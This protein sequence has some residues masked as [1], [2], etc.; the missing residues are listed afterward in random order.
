V[1]IFEPTCQNFYVTYSTYSCIFCCRGSIPRYQSTHY[2][3]PEPKESISAKT[4]R[5]FSNPLFETIG[6]AAHAASSGDR[7][8]KKLN[9]EELTSLASDDD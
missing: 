3:P 5:W 4:A 6:I 1:K 2:E 8:E 7:K 9:L